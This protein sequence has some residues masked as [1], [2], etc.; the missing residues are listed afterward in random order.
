MPQGEQDAGAV[1]AVLFVKVQVPAEKAAVK[2]MGVPSAA[3]V[4]LLNTCEVPVFTAAL[5]A[6]SPL[7]T[8][9]PVAGGFE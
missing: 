8:K 1:P 3:I 4:T 5:A 7:K 6:P 2:T 9:L